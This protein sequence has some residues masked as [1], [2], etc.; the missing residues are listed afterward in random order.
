MSP[1]HETEQ[2]NEKEALLII[3]SMISQSREELQ[4]NGIL[5]QLWGWLVFVS[6]ITN[7]NLL[8]FTEFEFHSVPWIILMPLGG[9]L[10]WWLKRKEHKLTRVKTHVDKIIRSFLMAFTISIVTVSFFMPIGDQ[11]RAFYPVIIIIYAIWLY[12]SGSLFAFKPF[13][14]GAYVNWLCAAAGFVWPDT[15]LH[16]VLIAAAVLFGFVIPGILLNRRYQQH[17]QGS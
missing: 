3:E 6:A 5:Y 17:V 10:T 4:D 1:N 12:L 15:R 2:L 11:W 14:W 7:F 8:V 9:F 16:L 13:I